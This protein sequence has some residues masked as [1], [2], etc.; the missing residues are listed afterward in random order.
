MSYVLSHTPAGRATEEEEGNDDGGE[1]LPPKGNK[2]TCITQP[3]TDILTIRI[4][5]R[6]SNDDTSDDGNQDSPPVK[7]KGE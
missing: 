2:G 7:A 5:V 1:D 6:E 4:A 3:T